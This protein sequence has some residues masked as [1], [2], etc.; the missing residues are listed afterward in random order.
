MGRDCAQ[1]S[2]MLCPNYTLVRTLGKGT[3][4]S[5]SVVQLQGQEVAMKQRVLKRKF[6]F[7]LDGSAPLFARELQAQQARSRPGRHARQ[8]HHAIKYCSHCVRRS[9]RRTA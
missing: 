3:V 8:P 6:N 9:L 1:R 5:V 2:Q 4:G 7:S